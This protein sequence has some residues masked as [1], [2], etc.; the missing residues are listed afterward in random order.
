MSPDGAT[1]NLISPSHTGSRQNLHDGALKQQSLNKFD[2]RKADQVLSTLK[3]DKGVSKPNLNT[4]DM[5]LLI[6]TQTLSNST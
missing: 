5:H 6:N 4:R 3:K 2:L 1:S